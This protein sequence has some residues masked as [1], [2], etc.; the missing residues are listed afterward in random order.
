MTCRKNYR[1]FTTIIRIIAVYLRQPNKIFNTMTQTFIALAIVALALL[2]VLWYL[3]RTL[4]GGK[5]DCGCGRGKKCN[6][7]HHHHHE[8]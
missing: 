7:K 5:P 2:W 3:V 1:K 6:N 8:K 4:R